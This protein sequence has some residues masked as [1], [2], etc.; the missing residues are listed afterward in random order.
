MDANHERN[1][2]ALLSGAGCNVPRAEDSHCD[3]HLEKEDNDNWRISAISERAHEWLKADLC[4]PLSQGLCDSF[5]V[6]MLGA[7]RFLKKLRSM[8]FSTEFVGIG[9]MDKY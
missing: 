9:G 6:D 5:V 1:I 4:S 7:D 8:G 3:F 2:E